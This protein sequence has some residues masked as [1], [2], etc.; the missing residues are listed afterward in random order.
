MK[1]KKRADFLVVQNKGQRFKMPA[2][3]ILYLEQAFLFSRV[4]YTATKKVGNAV[5]RNKA[6]RRLRALSRLF[7]EPHLK[8]KSIDFVLI[9]HPKLPDYP[10]DKLST[11]FKNAIDFIL[12]KTTQ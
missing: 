2:F 11:D 10:F 5:L 3:T 6:K 9:A 8:N 12:K 1:L 7:L 4:G